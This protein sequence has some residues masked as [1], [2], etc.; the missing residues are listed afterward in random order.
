MLSTDSES[1]VFVSV[2]V[3]PAYAT[4]KPADMTFEVNEKREGGVR[5]Q[6]DRPFYDSSISSSI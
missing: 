2:H 3:N 5:E 4:L 6:H 1:G